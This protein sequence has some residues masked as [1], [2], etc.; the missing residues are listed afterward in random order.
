VVSQAVVDAADATPASF[1]EIG[2]VQLKGLSEALRLFTARQ[3]TRAGS[4]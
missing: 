1:V 2:P 3:D 4:R